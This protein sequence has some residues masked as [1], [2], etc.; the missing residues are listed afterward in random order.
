MGEGG[1]NEGLTY[2]IAKPTLSANVCVDIIELSAFGR[3]S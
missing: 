2:N 1:E 3:S